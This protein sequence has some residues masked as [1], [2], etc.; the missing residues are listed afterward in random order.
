MNTLTS[1]R[2]DALEAFAAAIRRLNTHKAAADERQRI[3]PMDLGEATKLGREAL[4]EMMAEGAKPEDQDIQML[5]RL[6]IHGEAES[7]RTWAN[8][9]LLLVGVLL[10]TMGV[11]VGTV[12]AYH[13]F[14]GHTE[15]K[16][17]G[18]Y[19]AGFMVFGWTSLLGVRR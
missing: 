18:L 13:A 5:N 14:H 8:I 16:I 3:Q 1:K 15:A 9:L 11:V 19:A 4:D 17:I 2:N 6:V 10:I 12:G 7:D